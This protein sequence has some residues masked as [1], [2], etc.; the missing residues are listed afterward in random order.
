MNPLTSISQ[1]IQELKNI[2]TLFNT[3][4]SDLT[5]K[6]RALQ[7]NDHQKQVIEGFS[8]E[9]DRWISAFRASLPDL[10]RAGE[11]YEKIVDLENRIRDLG[12]PGTVEG[13]NK[14]SFSTVCLTS[15]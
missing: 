7:I 1:E 8:A 4:A 9:H 15:V 6:I 11:Y 12:I 2:I 14:Q 3:F 13:Q 10:D 5:A